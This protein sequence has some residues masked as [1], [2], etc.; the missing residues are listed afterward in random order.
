M[1]AYQGLTEFQEVKDLIKRVEKPK[2]L[3]IG[4]GTGAGANLITQCK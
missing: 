3:E 2:I 4:C 1:A